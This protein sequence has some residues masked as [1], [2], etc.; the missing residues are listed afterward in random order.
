MEVGKCPCQALRALDVQSALALDMLRNRDLL[1]WINIPD[2][3]NTPSNPMNNLY[4]ISRNFVEIGPF[5]G[6]EIADFKKRGVFK[7]GDY[8]RSESAQN[9][10]TIAQWIAEGSPEKT[11]SKK[12][13]SSPAKK[14]APASKV[15]TKPK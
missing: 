9:W 6:Q 14:R 2:S 15:V 12:K 4:F 10:E 1:R 7:D 5:Y 11:T 8:M 3:P 13:A